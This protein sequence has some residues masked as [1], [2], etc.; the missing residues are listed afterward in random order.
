MSFKPFRKLRLNLIQDISTKNINTIQDYIAEAL[1]QLLN[2]DHLDSSILTNIKLLP[3]LNK[4]GHNLG[5]SLGGY[6]ITRCHGGFPL[7]YDQQDLNT[8]PNLTLWLVS[9]TNITVNIL[10]Y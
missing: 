10:V 7:I 5:R 9:S 4:I 8:S 2:K 1:Q 6:I 3:G